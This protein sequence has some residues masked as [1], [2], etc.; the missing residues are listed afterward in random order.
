[1]HDSCHSQ[2]VQLRDVVELTPQEHNVLTTEEKVVNSTHG[3]GCSG[4]GWGS[5]DGRT[6][7]LAL[8]T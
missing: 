5:R 6:P 2:E 4:L 1:M 8:G 3:L 7:V